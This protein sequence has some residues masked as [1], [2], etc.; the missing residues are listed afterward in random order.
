MDRVA[1]DGLISLDRLATGQTGR[2]ER[3]VGCPEH[4]R[5]L[6][7]MGLRPGI[8]VRVLRCGKP[9]IIRVSGNRLCFRCSDSL[10]VLVRSHQVAGS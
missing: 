2:I 7:E 1:D 3:L 10:G 9:C 5:R 8:T 6:E 4:V